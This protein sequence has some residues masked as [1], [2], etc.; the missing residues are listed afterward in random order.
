MK[1]HYLIIIFIIIT[2]CL[3]GCGKYQ[4]N[5]YSESTY[6][7]GTRFTIFV[8][9]ETCVEYFVSNGTYNLGNVMPRYN[10]N[11]T[12]KINNKCLNDLERK[13]E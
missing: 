12:L 11:G 1:K 10:Q 13:G 4:E 3:C 7:N 5:E 8:D 9:A 6:Y 2:F